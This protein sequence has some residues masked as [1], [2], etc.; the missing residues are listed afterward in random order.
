MIMIRLP[1]RSLSLP[2]LPRSCPT[3]YHSTLV[4]PFHSSTSSLLLMNAW[5][6]AVESR[7]RRLS[8]P[9]HGGMGWD[10]TSVCVC[11]WKVYSLINMLVGIILLTHVNNILPRWTF[12]S[13]ALCDDHHHH[14]H[15]RRR[16][17]HSPLRSVISLSVSLCVVLHFRR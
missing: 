13:L 3:R 2:S 15:R 10:G 4:V 17:H 8:S 7:P 9:G 12:N 1:R 5:P 6:R 16:R 14:Y 11:V